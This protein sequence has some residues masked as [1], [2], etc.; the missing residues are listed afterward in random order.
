[1]SASPQ[2]KKI[3]RPRAHG[4][5][6]ICEER[7]MTPKRWLK[8]HEAFSAALDRDPLDRNKFLAETFSDDADLQLQ[9]A[10]L[11]RDA[12]QA[13]GDG[14]LKEPAWVIDD[15]PLFLSDFRH[16][17]SEFSQIEYIGQGGMGVVYKAYQKHFDRWVALKF[18][19]PSRLLSPS[20]V[21]RF[22]SE[23]QS[24]A[25]LRHPNIVTV[26]ETGEHDGHPF[27]VMEL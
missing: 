17:D 2:W 9:V 14:F 26:H 27:F 5:T 1:M 21:E 15:I 12:E 11:L 7:R 13:D 6:G 25:R 8:V 23:A 20:D 16:G 19:S 10:R 18:T 4:S 3:G 22:R 24:M